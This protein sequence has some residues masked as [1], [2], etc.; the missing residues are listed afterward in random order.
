MRRLIARLE[1]QRPASPLLHAR[2]LHTLALATR[3]AE[4]M[5]LAERALGVLRADEA[6]DPVAVSDAL[7]AVGE[8]AY[9]DLND[10]A[11]AR[12]AWTES[13][14]LVEAA[15]GPDHPATLTVLGNLGIVLED[16]G[17]ALEAH[18]RVFDARLK[19]Y[20]PDSEAVAAAANNWA[21][22]LVAGRR[23]A[24]AEPLFAQAAAFAT[25]LGAAHRERATPPPSLGIVRRC[26]GI[27]GRHVR[28][29]RRASMVAGRRPLGA[30]GVRDVR[31]QIATAR[32]ATG[33]RPRRPRDR[34]TDAPCASRD[35]L[36]RVAFEEAVR[37]CPGV[38]AGRSP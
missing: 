27:E 32:T 7:N 10:N 23:Y 1:G 9:L 22:S 20:G 11:R 5:V 18:R 26:G 30:C 14:R 36:G 33:R 34:P 37:A 38:V 29:A 16:P 31:T 19:M 24:E 3:G 2:A 12:A 21:Y 6:P 13:L 4:G 8:L 28:S 17:Q 35:R 15:K 25:S